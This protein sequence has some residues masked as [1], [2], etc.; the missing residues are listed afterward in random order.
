MQS[1][2]LKSLAHIQTGYTFRKTTVGNSNE[3]VKVLQSKNIGTD[4]YINPE[5]VD[6]FV[7][8]VSHST[9]FVKSGDI[10][11]TSRGKFQA[12]VVK[13][14]EPLLAASSVF[15]IKVSSKKILPEYLAIYLNSV[16]CQKQL[17]VV[18]RM[19]TIETVT[20]QNIADI[21]VAVPPISRQKLFVDLYL[22]IQA[23]KRLLQQKVQKIENIF[24]SVLDT[25]VK[26]TI[27][28]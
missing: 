16:H 8:N 1:S 18:R 23:Q 22:N 20:K 14:S 12:A 13:S 28:Q 17:Q 26:G 10:I 2:K 7:P 19:G 21:V 4:L 3:Q 27:W 15:I 6:L 5:Q 9:A 25:Q 11:F 24:S